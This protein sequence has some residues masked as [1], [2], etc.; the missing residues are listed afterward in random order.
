MTKTKR[1]QYEA[2]LKKLRK[3][4]GDCKHCEKCHMYISG[5][6][7]A[8]GCDVLPQTDFD[9]IAETM[10]SLHSEALETIAFE[11]K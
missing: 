2:A 6:H 11:L 10:A 4:T 5:W 3:C 9:A 1:K 7:Y 8:F